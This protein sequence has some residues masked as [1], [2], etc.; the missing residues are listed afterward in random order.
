MEPTDGFAIIASLEQGVAGS[1]I[2]ALLNRLGINLKEA[3][4]L[5]QAAERTLLRHRQSARLDRALAEQIV[6]LEHLASH[7]YSVFEGKPDAFKRWLRYP[8]AELNGR[9]PL[10]YLTTVT[11]IRLVDDVLTRIE[12]GVYV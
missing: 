9:S 5:F 1:R 4:S 6:L 2:E 3:A 10:H 7:G 11:G 12:Y 8:L